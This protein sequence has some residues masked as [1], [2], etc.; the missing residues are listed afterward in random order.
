[1]FDG[2]QLRQ[3]AGGYYAGTSTAL[4]MC[5]PSAR[6]GKGKNSDLQMYGTSKLYNVLAVKEIQNRIGK[7][8]GALASEQYT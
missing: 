3:D 7:P 8:E 5:C 1:M 4:G 6:R 2:T